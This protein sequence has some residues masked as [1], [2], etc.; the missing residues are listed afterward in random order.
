VR[1]PAITRDC[2]KTARVEYYSRDRF[3]SVN[4][5][6]FVDLFFAQMWR[7]Q[8]QEIACTRKKDKCTLTT[9]VFIGLSYNANKRRV[10]TFM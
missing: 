1:I 2:E 3:G 8:Q 10:S 9:T 5:E 4:V 6:S 7:K